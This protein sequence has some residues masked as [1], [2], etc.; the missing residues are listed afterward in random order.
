MSAL[1]KDANTEW[2]SDR[3]LKFGAD[4]EAL[5]DI[6]RSSGL[7]RFATRGP[8]SDRTLLRF[9]SQSVG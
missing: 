8:R 2:K 7:C 9:R 3:S 1:Q 5:L 4:L 6:G